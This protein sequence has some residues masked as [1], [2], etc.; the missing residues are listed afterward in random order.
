MNWPTAT[1]DPIRRLRVLAGSVPGATLVEQTL[2]APLDDVW[3]VATGF[4]TYLHRFEGG[5]RSARV[6]AAR[7]PE[8]DRAI[9]LRIQTIVGLP[10]RMDVIVRPGY[11]WME[12]RPRIYVVGLAAIADGQR[13]RFAH[14]EGLPVPGGKLAGPLI[15]L[16]MASDLRRIEALAQERRRR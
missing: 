9:D 15:R 14:V 13:T 10:M 2:D 3:A 6:L 11:C 8:D 7:G 16:A 12:A 1:L 4:E 5:I